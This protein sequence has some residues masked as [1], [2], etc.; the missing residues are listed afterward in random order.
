MENLKN[1]D[2]T[3]EIGDK[4]TNIDFE[5]LKK[6]EAI[7]IIRKCLDNFNCVFH[8][9][10]KEAENIVIIMGDFGNF[11]LF[12]DDSDN[13]YQ[14]FNIAEKIYKIFKENKHF[15]EET[16]DSCQVFYNLVK[17]HNDETGETHNSWNK[18]IIFE[19]C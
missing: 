2:I 1:F 15:S 4:K 16:L 5:N 12:L 3:K 14:F 9:V 13:R 19:F 7:S 17:Y 8:K 10:Y 11:E 18:S 6:F